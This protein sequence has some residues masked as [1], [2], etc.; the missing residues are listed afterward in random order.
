MS[1]P[2]FFLTEQILAEETEPEFV[3]RLSPDDA[4][5]AQVLRL[6]PGEHIAVI[7]AELDYFECA[8]TRVD[9]RDIV[10]RIA[11]HEC[12]HKPDFEV[13]LC[14]GLAKSDK[15][16]MVFRH[17]TE[18]GVRGFIPWCSARSVVKL[19]DKKAQ[20]R[21]ER[22]SSI[23]KSAAMQSG[24]PAIP[25]VYP[26]VRGKELSRCLAEFDCVI[27]CWEECG[28]TKRLHDILAHAQRNHIGLL[29]EQTVTQRPLKV[30]MVIGPEGG[31]TSEEIDMLTS[32]HEQAHVITLG[33][34]ILRTETAGIVA[35][36]LAIYE[37]GGLQ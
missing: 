21:L 12:A 6:S 35:S 3:L 1:L 26:I 37:L 31:L 13:Y 5:H 29:S 34:G 30:L 11:Q 4:H 19:D 28:E 24:Q 15:V 25:Q 32:A 2:R 36:A 9:T 10:V 20:K 16:D 18:L 23:V 22:L 14:Q 27:I 17:A 33:E 8:I 7:D